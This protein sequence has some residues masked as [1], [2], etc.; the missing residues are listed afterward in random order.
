MWEALENRLHAMFVSME[1]IVQAS[2]QLSLS[3]SPD[4]L[5]ALFDKHK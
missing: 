4:A 5:F 2:Y 3:L 1:D